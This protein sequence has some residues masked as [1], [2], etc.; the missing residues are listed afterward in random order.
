MTDDKLIPIP[1]RS[2]SSGNQVAANGKQQFIEAHPLQGLQ[3][4]ST[5]EG[6]AAANTKAFGGEVAAAVIAA[7]SRQI[8]QDFSE[9][10]RENQRLNDRIEKMRDELETTR[11]KNAVFAEKIRSEG[12]NKHLRNL[13]ITVGTALI[14]IGITLNRTSVNGLDSYSIG[15]LV[16]G[17]LLLFLGWFSGAKEEKA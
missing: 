2:G 9:V 6:L 7:A 17:V 15:A 12:K 1:D 11:T 10:K 4:A 13:S 16:F 8:N 3:I 5:I 14:G